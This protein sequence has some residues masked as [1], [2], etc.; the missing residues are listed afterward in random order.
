MPTHGHFSVF[1]CLD[2]SAALDRGTT[3]FTLL[4]GTA[5]SLVA[6]TVQAP[7]SLPPP[8]LLFLCSFASSVPPSNVGVLLAWTS[9]L[10]S[11][12]SLSM[13]EAEPPSPALVLHI[14]SVFKIFTS[15]SA[16]LPLPQ[17]ALHGGQEHRL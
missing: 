9:A 8:W 11:F 7:I 5:S 2:L 16:A 10:F 3:D 6:M 13:H 17:A 14:S 15:I 4:S 12:F 1:S